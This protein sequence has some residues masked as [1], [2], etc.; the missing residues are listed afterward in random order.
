MFFAH[1]YH[2]RSLIAFRNTHSST[3]PFFQPPATASNRCGCHSA[4][5]SASKRPSVGACLWCDRCAC[6]VHSTPL[7]GTVQAVSTHPLLSCAVHEVRSQ[8][9]DPCQL[10][11]TCICLSQACHLPLCSQSCVPQDRKVQPKVNISGRLGNAPDLPSLSAFAFEQFGLPDAGPWAVLGS[12]DLTSI[13]EDVLL[14]IKGLGAKRAIDVMRPRVFQRLF[15]MAVAVSPLPDE[16]EGRSPQE[17][18]A[19]KVCEINNHPG[20]TSPCSP[21]SCFQA[22]CKS[23]RPPMTLQL[24]CSHKCCTNLQIFKITPEAKL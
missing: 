1:F 12:P 4:V 9:L 8:A 2:N 18:Q 5:V 23:P 13:P 10:T 24:L 16:G 19:W 14:P 15:P 6:S 11:C 3:W 17:V 7:H 22:A 20:G 21:H